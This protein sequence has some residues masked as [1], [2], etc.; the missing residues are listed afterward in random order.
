M[1]NFHITVEASEENVPYIKHWV[2]SLSR[3]IGKTFVTFE[4]SDDQKWAEEIEQQ[5]DEEGG[6]EL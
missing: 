6:I 2:T 3:H 4:G 5:M 1:L